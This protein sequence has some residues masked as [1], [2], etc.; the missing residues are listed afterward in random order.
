MST[1]ATVEELPAGPVDLLPAAGSSTLLAQSDYVVLTVPLVSGTQR[2]I[3]AAELAAMKPS[4]YLINVSRGK[5]V[6]QQAL[7]TALKDGAI[8]GACLDVFEQEPL[9]PDDPLWDMPNVIITPHCAG[10]HE[11][12]DE[13]AAALFHDNLARYMAGRASG[14]CRGRG[15]RLL[16]AAAD[17]RAKRIGAGAISRAGPSTSLVPLTVPGSPYRASPAFAGCDA[18]RAAGRPGRPG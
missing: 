8:A 14:Q 7:T 1:A 13:R 6:D 11:R 3:G 5:V 18:P 10:S 17:L 4:S 9:P 12:Y 16:E 15:P 2:L